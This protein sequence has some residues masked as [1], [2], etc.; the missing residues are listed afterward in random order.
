MT[1]TKRVRT[2]LGILIATTAFSHPVRAQ[3]QSAPAATALP[4]VYNAAISRTQV[5]QRAA[6]WLRRDIPYSQDNQKATWDLNRG[7]RYR[8]D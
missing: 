7:R 1:P 6:D 8:P 4:V 5:M 2:V 3:A